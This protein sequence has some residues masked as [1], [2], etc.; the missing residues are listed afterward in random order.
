MKFP[1]R[2]ANQ[3][4]FIK[5]ST[6]EGKYKIDETYNE[7]PS[8][9]DNPVINKPIHFKPFECGQ[10]ILNN[11]NAMCGQAFMAISKDMYYMEM[12]KTLTDYNDS[13]NTLLSN[14]NIR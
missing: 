3:K 6:Q 2:I 9:T 4:T 1:W 14:V 8:V 7:E 5:L 11:I 12:Y 13:N 10:N